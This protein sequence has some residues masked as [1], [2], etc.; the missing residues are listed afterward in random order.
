MKQIQKWHIKNIHKLTW[1]T[2][3]HRMGLIRYIYV[4]LRQGM[5]WSPVHD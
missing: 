5:K 2:L 1:Q 4:N 3:R